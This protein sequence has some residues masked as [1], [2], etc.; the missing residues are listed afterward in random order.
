[1]TLVETQKA[2]AQADN[3]RPIGN[4]AYILACLVI[5]NLPFVGFYIIGTGSRAN[6]LA[7]YALMGI[8][9]ARKAKPG[10]VVLFWLIFLS[11]IVST[12]ARIFSFS[13]LEFTAAFR[14]IPMLTPTDGLA[15]YAPFAL[16]FVAGIA[17]TWGI[18]RYRP[19]TPDKLTM[20]FALVTLVAV[21][22]EHFVASVPA[23]NIYGPGDAPFQS[24]MMQTDFE[25]RTLALPENGK[26]LLIVAES[27]GD[28]LDPAIRQAIS[29]PLM[30]APVTAQFDVQEGTSRFAGHTPQGELRELCGRYLDYEDI[31]A[32]AKADM[33]S[34]LP[35]QASEAGVETVGIHGFSGWM[36]DRTEWYPLVGFDRMV[37][38]EDLQNQQL[39][40]CKGILVGLCDIPLLETR[41]AEELQGEGRKMVYFLT[42]TSHLPFVAHEYGEPFDC[43]GEDRAIAD[44]QAC[45]Q[46]NYLNGLMGRVAA[47]IA[48]TGPE[49]DSVL[50]VGDHRPPFIKRDAKEMFRVDTVPYFYLTRK[51]NDVAHGDVAE[52]VESGV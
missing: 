41:I 30:S 45:Q 13:L 48:S 33:P 46:A 14:F 2:A 20:P 26:T 47:L 31:D 39:K 35:E 40:E 51:R 27:Y 49:L 28:Y 34:C 18:Y 44:F 16:L 10:Y 36:F 37:F 1:M 12:A 6:Y 4:F 5:C 11:D 29:A 8:L 15:F 21:G 19:A 25:A 7:L 38:A 3:R 32:A 23:A 52:N 43:E 42:L 50:I 9:L 17:V 24:A 22:A